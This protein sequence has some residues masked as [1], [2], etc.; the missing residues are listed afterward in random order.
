V[1]VLTSQQV[2]LIKNTKY[3]NMSLYQL[4]GETNGTLYNQVAQAWN[5][6]FYFRSMA[7]NAGGGATGNVSE[8]INVSF[9]SFEKFKDTFSN[10]ANNLFGSGWVWLVKTKSNNLE[11]ITTSDAGN[12]IVEG[13]GTPLLVMDVWEHAYFLGEQSKRSCTIYR[14]IHSS[15]RINRLA[16]AQCVSMH[17]SK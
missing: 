3:E 1:R 12:P 8:A 6:N 15:T 4:L 9:G 7:P 5:H 13:K 11:V 14:A 10:A 16:Y 2:D 17:G